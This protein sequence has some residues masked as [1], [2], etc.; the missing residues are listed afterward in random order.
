[1]A[2]ITLG[3]FVERLRKLDQGGLRK[4]LLKTTR[5]AALG[6]ERHAKLTVSTRSAT[7]LGVR[8]GRL[9]G[10]ISS[11]VEGRDLNLVLKV[12]AGGT[13]GRGTVRYARI[14]ELGGEV[15]ALAGKYLRIPLRGG[16]ALTG[17]GVDRY[18]P[19]LRQT[20]AGLFFVAKSKAGNLLLFHQLT[21]QP[22]Y[23]LRQSVRI[24]KRPYLAPAIEWARAELSRALL[25]DLRAG[26]E[27]R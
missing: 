8:T 7:T 14:H 19:P 17:A 9:R 4:T 24:P 11:S 12:R 10:S 21:R 16:P 25:A 13:G 22:W 23:V 26:L 15:K 6:A 20:G 3:Q 1:M 2:T 5:A 18:P 27:G